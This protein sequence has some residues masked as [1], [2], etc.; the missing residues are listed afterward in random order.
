[1]PTPCSYDYAIV[2]VVPRV[3]RQEFVNAGVILS[4]PAQDFLEAR[5]ELDEQRLRTLI[6]RLGRVHPRHGGAVG[7]GGRR[8]ERHHPS[9]RDQC[10][11]HE[12]RGHPS[13]HAG[14]ARGA[15]VFGQRH[16]LVPL[17]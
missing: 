15:E 2:R 11:A 9:A 4:C 14:G 8:G 17:P 7:G 10:R 6:C 12:Q 5:I 16:R 3:E 13:S 1:M